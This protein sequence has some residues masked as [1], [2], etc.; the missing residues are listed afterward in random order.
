AS[1]FNIKFIFASLFSISP[2]NAGT[3]I[4]NKCLGERREVW[5]GWGQEGKWGEI[6]GICSHYIRDGEW[7]ISYYS[8]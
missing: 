3:K 8:I 7:K 5:V 4:L 1:L 2:W 6:G